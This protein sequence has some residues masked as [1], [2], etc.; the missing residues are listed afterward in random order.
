MLRRA[1]ESVREQIEQ[2]R[3]IT[4]LYVRPCVCVF[5]CVSVRVCV[6]ISE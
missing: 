2:E 4:Y 3:G 5:V 6:R 1:R